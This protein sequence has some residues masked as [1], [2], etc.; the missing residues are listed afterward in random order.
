MAAHLR[1]TLLKTHRCTSSRTHLGVGTRWAG[2]HGQRHAVTA[3]ALGR[4]RPTGAWFVLLRPATQAPCTGRSSPA[5]LAEGPQT[6]RCSPNVVLWVGALAHPTPPQVGLSPGLTQM[7]NAASLTLTQCRA[8]GRRPRPPRRGCPRCPWCRSRPP[9][10]QPPRTL[11][12]Q[13]QVSYIC[14]LNQGPRHAVS[15]TLV[16]QAGRSPA[17]GSSP[18]LRPQRAQRGQ[19]A[20]RAQ[21]AQPPSV[22]TCMSTLASRRSLR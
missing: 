6:C 11:P 21:R 14:H 12:A 19:R 7:Q 17:P 20:Q 1:R 8:G 5:W 15:L 9:P 18:P 10:E 3:P 22:R 2:G 16:Q 13:R 4:T